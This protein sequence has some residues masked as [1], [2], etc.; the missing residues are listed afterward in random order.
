MVSSGPC[1]VPGEESAALPLSKAL[2]LHSLSSCTDRSAVQSTLNKG[3]ITVT[4]DCSYV[5]YFTEFK[6]TQSFSNKSNPHYCPYSIFLL[7]VLTSHQYYVYFMPEC[8]LRCTVHIHIHIPFR[9]IH[10]ALI[11]KQLI[12]WIKGVNVLQH[13]MANV[14]VC[15]GTVQ[16]ADN[17]VLPRLIS[18]CLSL[19][20]IGQVDV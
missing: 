9:T 12:C 7:N 16:H 14:T 11:W 2:N 18:R 10:M 15:S 6:S 20:C 3:G 19:Q 13:H 1:E 17:V 8:I 4:M 5:I